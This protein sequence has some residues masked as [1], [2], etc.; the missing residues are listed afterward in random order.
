MLP[1][2]IQ[3]LPK[4]VQIF[5]FPHTY[6][7]KQCTNVVQPQRNVT[8]PCTNITKHSPIFYPPHTIVIKQC[9]NIDLPNT[10]VTQPC[11]TV[12]LPHICNCYVNL[13]GRYTLNKG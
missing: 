11:T 13:S 7:T 4:S 12:A 5:G 9:T 2:P 8:K 1:Y 3:I 6:V 10:N